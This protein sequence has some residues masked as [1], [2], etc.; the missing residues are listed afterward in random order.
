[1]TRRGMFLLVLGLVLLGVC[2]WSETI[3]IGVVEF[4]LNNDIGLENA[5]FIIADLV[6]TEIAKTA[7]YEVQE[8]LLLKKVLEEQELMLSGVIEESEIS[9]IGRIFDVD[10][11]ITGSVMKIG[12]GIT[13]TGRLISVTSGKVLKTDSVTSPSLDELPG[14]VQVLAN[15]LANIPREA[16]EIRQDLALREW[17]R[18]EIGGGAGYAYNNIRY[19]SAG[20][21][22]VFRY[23]P[24]LFTLWVEGSPLSGIPNVEFGGTFN[25]IPF[26]G[27]GAAYGMYFDNEIDYVELNYLHFGF[28]VRPRLSFE[29]GLFI[30]GSLSGVVWTETGNKV[31]GIS[32]TWSFLSNFSVWLLYKINDNISIRIKYLGV[33]LPPFKDELPPAYSYPDSD[34]EY[35]SGKFTVSA[36]YAFT[37]G[38]PGVRRR[39]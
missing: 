18:M 25:V 26:L 4:E 6:A 36:M 28:M 23:V 38:G 27:L 33:E 29:F 14:E 8:R 34:Y 1:M 7:E 3:S 13:I 16:F 31:T 39:P 9:E 2:G 5:G 20:L 11:I 19:G 12:S 22:A 32:G 15:G 21:N 37:I 35:M 10:A 30:G 24:T 17:T